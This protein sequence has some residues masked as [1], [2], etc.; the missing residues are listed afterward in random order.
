M[1]I[2]FFIYVKK[3]NKLLT[4]YVRGRGSVLFY[5][6]D[7]PISSFYSGI[8]YLKQILFIYFCTSLSLS[9]KYKEWAGP[10]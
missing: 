2:F 9:T 3:E 7:F 8:T 10:C 4:W 1:N 6:I 5:S